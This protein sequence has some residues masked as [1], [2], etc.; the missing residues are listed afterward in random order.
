MKQ[1]FKNIFFRTTQELNDQIQE[2][3][4]TDAIIDSII[5]IHS[6]MFPTDPIKFTNVICCQEVFAVYHLKEKF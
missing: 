3:L 4:D 2:L 5:P 6:K 1:Q